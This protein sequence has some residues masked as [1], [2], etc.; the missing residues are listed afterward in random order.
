VLT[1]NLR[2][3][4]RVGFLGN[5]MQP[6]LVYYIAEVGDELLFCIDALA[7]LVGIT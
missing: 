1:V 4:I 3:V 2:I 6:G 7:A 5:S